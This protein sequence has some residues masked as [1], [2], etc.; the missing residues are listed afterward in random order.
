MESIEGKNILWVEDDLFLYNII[1]SLILKEKCKLTNAKDGEEALR[2]A[3]ENSYDLIVLDILLPGM[4]GMDVLTHLKENEKTKN[5]PVI[6]LSNLDD[7]EVVGKINKIGVEG[8][9]V[10]ALVNPIEI[11]KKIKEIL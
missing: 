1:S 7:E 6:I 3:L 2:F 10:K 9:F 8:F 11:V 5:T 4:N